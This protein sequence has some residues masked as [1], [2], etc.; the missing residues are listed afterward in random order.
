MM[1]WQLK[2]SDFMVKKKETNLQFQCNPGE[3]FDL[4]GYEWFSFSFIWIPGITD[5]IFYR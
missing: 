5:S 1:L 3:L 2:A 4:F